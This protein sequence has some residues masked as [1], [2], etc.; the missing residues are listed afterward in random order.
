LRILAFV[1]EKK[2]LEYARSKMYEYREK[3]KL[4]LNELPDSIYKKA[5]EQL[6]E[7]VTERDK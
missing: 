2:G 5:F 1:K 3:S 6:I 7:F 4:M